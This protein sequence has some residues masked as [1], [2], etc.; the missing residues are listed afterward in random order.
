TLSGRQRRGVWVKMASGQD[1]EIFVLDEPTTYLD[2]AH[3][4]EVL[5]LLDK[6]NREQGRTIIMVLHD[7]NQAQRIADHIIA[8]KKGEIVKTGA[9]EEVIS[10]DVLREVVHVDAV[11]GKDPRTQKP[12]CLNYNIWRG[13]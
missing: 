4:R 12:L 11:I 13:E 1:A 10:K 3:Q 2:M 7:L 6:L 9:C 8:L 5:E